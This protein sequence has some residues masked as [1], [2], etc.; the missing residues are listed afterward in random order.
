MVYMKKLVNIWYSCIFCLLL[1]ESY[2]CM[3]QEN[4]KS[5]DEFS[6]QQ[7]ISDTLGSENYRATIVHN[8]SFIED[9]AGKTII[10]VESLLGSP[11]FKC[12]DEDGVS[13]MY[14]IEYMRRNN[15]RMY[16]Y[17]PMNDC[18]ENVSLGSFIS[19]LFEGENR[20]LVLPLVIYTCG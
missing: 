10:E 8:T 2:S 3:S 18:K 5:S 16:T 7:W 13:Y 1:L 11:D 20:I 14:N 9:L 4:I 6:T 19:L 12:E 15:H 17:K